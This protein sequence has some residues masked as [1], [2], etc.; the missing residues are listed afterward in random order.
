MAEPRGIKEFISWKPE[1]LTPYIE[2]GLLYKQTKMLVYGKYKSMKSMLI[3]HLGLCLAKGEPWLGIQVHGPGLKVLYLQLE[4][5][6]K[7]L[8]RRLLKM[9]GGELETKQDILFWTEHVLKLD[10]NDGMRVLENWLKVHKPDV[11]IIDPL[12]KVLSVNMSDN[13][14]INHVLDELDRIIEEYGVSIVLVTHSRKP[15]A[16]EGETWGTDNM[17][18]GVLLSAWGDSVLEVTRDND[19][20]RVSMD[21]VRHAEDELQ[22]VVVNVSAGL[23][24]SIKDVKI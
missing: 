6:E 12:Y 19:A 15:G 5:P 1:P 10:T 24:F 8:H 13:H 7:L 21:V 14:A 18:G 4:I 23:Q 3:Q 17:L 11:L 20:L 16:N 9:L 22:P 2:K